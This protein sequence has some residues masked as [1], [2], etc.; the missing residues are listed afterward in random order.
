MLDGGYIPVESG[1]FVGEG[2]HAMSAKVDAITTVGVY[3]GDTASRQITL[4]T[5][6]IY[7]ALMKFKRR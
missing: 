2:S 7:N 3:I 4:I 1:N 6:F 5:C